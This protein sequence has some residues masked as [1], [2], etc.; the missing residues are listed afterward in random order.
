[1]VDKMG[2][3]SVI[4]IKNLIMYITRVY[5]SRLLTLIIKLINNLTM[6]QIVCVVE[7]VITTVTSIFTYKVL[8]F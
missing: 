6:I 1:M 2:I 3:I 8:P 4:I 7:S 5:K